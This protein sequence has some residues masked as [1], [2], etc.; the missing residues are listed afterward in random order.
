MSD[1]R[2]AC[3]GEATI[4]MRHG[5]E[6]FEECAH[7]GAAVRWDMVD[8]PFFGFENTC[9]LKPRVSLD[10][11]SRTVTADYRRYTDG[12]GKRFEAAHG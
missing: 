4:E 5:A 8:H 11:D 6:T 1:E 10:L 7:C 12:A 2:R 3:Q 9:P